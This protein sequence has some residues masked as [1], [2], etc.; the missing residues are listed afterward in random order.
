MKETDI[1]K[2]QMLALSNEGLR[3]FRN[4][5][6]EAWAGKA[7]QSGTVIV[8]QKPYRIKYGLCDGSGDIIG[9]MPLT[10]TPDMVGNKIGVF[11]SVETKTKKGRLQDNQKKFREMVNSLGGIGL[12]CRSVDDCIKGIKEW[13]AKMNSGSL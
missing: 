1:M 8:M 12:V 9:I 4:N 11:V 6:G 5:V 2:S 7:I 10:I 3:V 13:I